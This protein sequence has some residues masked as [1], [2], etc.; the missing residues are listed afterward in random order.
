M[1]VLHTYVYVHS[2]VLAYLHTRAKVYKHHKHQ[3]H[4]SHPVAGALLYWPIFWDGHVHTIVVFSSTK[5]TEYRH[6]C[7]HAWK[8][9]PHMVLP[10][11]YV[12]A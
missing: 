2:Q 8:L 11:R 10:Q 7:T 6:T 4:F 5:K 3:L 12:D 9:L 1:P